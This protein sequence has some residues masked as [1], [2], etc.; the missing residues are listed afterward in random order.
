MSF[1]QKNSQALTKLRAVNLELSSYCN[2]S[3][4]FCLRNAW[5]GAGKNQNMQ[6]ELLRKILPQ[7]SKLK[8]IDLTGWGE[9]LMHPEFAR[10]LRLIRSQ[11]SQTLSFTS[12]GILL[13]QEKINS[14]IENQVDVICFSI[15]ASCKAVYEKRRGRFWDKIEKEIK[16]LLKRRNQLG[17]KKPKIYASY[18]LQKSYLF[19]LKPF[20]QKMLEW[21]MDGILFQQMGGVFSPKDL[22]EITYSGYYDID[23]SDDALFQLIN[24]I[25]LEFKGELEVIFPEKVHKERQWGC[26]V[27][28]IDQIFIKANGEASPCCALGYP[29]RFLKKDKKPKKPTTLI[30]GNLNDESLDEIWQKDIARKFQ[31]DM[32]K[33]GFSPACDDCIGLYMR[34]E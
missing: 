13:D 20:A 10:A 24:D 9:P 18:L 25:A 4:R 31:Q 21:G 28:P 1:S 2:L 32:L 12:N 27:F 29:V 7:I 8:T 11:F 34:R 5:E 33:K 22:D 17:L 6:M 3:C 16:S 15:D 14:I 30:L 26:G 23:F 19:D